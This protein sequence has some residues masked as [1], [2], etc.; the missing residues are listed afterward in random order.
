MNNDTEFTPHALSVLTGLYY[1][2]AT[3]DSNSTELVMNRSNFIH[4]LLSSWRN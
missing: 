3:T 4:Y 2:F 1:E